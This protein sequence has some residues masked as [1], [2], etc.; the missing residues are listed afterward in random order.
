MMLIQLTSNL[1]NISAW[2]SYCKTLVAGTG[3]CLVCLPKL[4]FGTTQD[5][6]RCKVLLL[7]KALLKKI[8]INNV[9]CD[10]YHG[11]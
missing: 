7:V 2:Y 9:L 3:V 11:K 8:L 10:A 6:A 1:L 4:P 5:A